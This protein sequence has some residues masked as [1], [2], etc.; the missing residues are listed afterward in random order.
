MRTAVLLLALSGA[1]T[2]APQP[3]WRTQVV[4]LGTGTPIPSPD[5]SGPAVAVIVD[6]AA[7]LFDAGAGVVRRAA[8]AGQAGVKAFA[9]AQPGG[10]PSPRFERVFI[11]HLHSDHTLGLADAIFTPWIQ[12]REAPLDVYGPAGLA[13]LVQSILDGNAA[14]IRE[15]IEAPAGPSK[16]G[17]RARAHEVTPGEIFRDARVTV[18]AFAVPHSKWPQAFGYRIDTPDRSIVISGDTVESDAVANACNGCDILI[19]EVISDAVFRAYPPERQAYHGA[20][21]TLATQVGRVATKGRAKLLVLTH[22]LSHGVSD[23]VVLAE[24]RSTYAGRVVLAKDLDVFPSASQEQESG[25]TRVAV[26]GQIRGRVFDEYGASI[27]DAFVTVQPWNPEAD[28]T[29]FEVVTDVRGRFDFGGVRPG[30]YRV[31]GTARGYGTTVMMQEV[32]AGVETDV[33]IVVRR[34]TGS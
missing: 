26:T 32:A 6:D 20:A 17:W 28:L 23:D 34:N 18:R 29:R 31:T 2:Q 15:R 27:P 22:V 25:T 19:H 16:D 30:A 12:G 4:M 7:Y 1:L 33:T 11:T 3:A 13:R 8:A 21:H 5:R 14:D 9:P 10:Q 24:V